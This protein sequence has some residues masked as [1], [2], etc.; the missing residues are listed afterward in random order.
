MAKKKIAPVTRA[1]RATFASLA[2]R[3][4]YQTQVR[5]TAA[6]SPA[7][8]PDLAKTL[9]SWSQGFQGRSERAV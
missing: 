3:I 5:E 1:K 2:L 9:G 7:M 8:S 4:R 6:K